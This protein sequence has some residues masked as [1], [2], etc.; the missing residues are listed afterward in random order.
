MHKT[1]FAPSPTGLIHLGNARTALFSY[2]FAKGNQG[3]FL[4]R[5]E[6]TDIERS[7][8][9]YATEL[10]KDL[11]WLNLQWQE[12]VTVEGP[13]APY[14]Q[15]QRMPIYEK[16]YQE[17]LDQGLAYPC[18]CTEEQLALSRKLQRARGIAP[19][20][21]GTCRSLSKDEVAKKLAEGLKPALRFRIPN[22]TQITFEDIVKGPQTFNADDIGDFI[23][24]RSNEMPSF[25]FCNAIDDSLMGVTHAL[26]GE[27]HLTNTP[28]QIM[29]LNALNLRAPQYGHFSLILGADGSPLSKRNG[30]RSI[31][32]LRTMGYLPL[33]VT[34]YLARLG[35][36]Y[37]CNDFLSLEELANQFKQ[38]A[39]AKSPARYDE[40]QLTHW[41]KLAI[42]KLTEEECW[43]WFGD[44]IKKLIP[45]EKQALFLRA[46]KPNVLFPQDAKVWAE[47]F[48]E[49][50]AEMA[51]EKKQF[52]QQA[53][54]NYFA[55][56]IEVLAE[57]G[58]DS[59]AFFNALKMKLNINGKSLYM[60]ARIALTGQEHGPEMQLIFE[61]LGIDEV[62]KRFEEI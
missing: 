13:H 26:R 58:L 49:K 55:A 52:L 22:N 11:L 42:E 44:E 48:F 36:Y 1:R 20:Y 43:Q 35:H 7:K 19:R 5:M 51:E 14:W 4:L 60:P 31:S 18:F 46:V 16:Y 62:K 39:L 56:A 17:L 33:A 3:T 12:G 2:L 47:L 15:A 8:D 34:N 53:G 32:E 6:D 27:D 25:M 10:Q 54:K 28:R 59:K 23:I 38:H 24:R 45:E 61:L 9:D 57:T 37:E 21:A 50:L 29:I 41:Q 40:T 30:S